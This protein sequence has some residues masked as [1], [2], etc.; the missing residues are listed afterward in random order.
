MACPYGRGLGGG[1]PVCGVVGDACWG[2][3]CFAGVGFVAGCLS[4]W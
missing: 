4:F 3:W 1:C 2:V